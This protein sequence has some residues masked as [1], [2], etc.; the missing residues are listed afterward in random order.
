FPGGLVRVERCAALVHVGD[1][2]RFTEH[3]L[4]G[5]RLLLAEDHPEKRRFAGAVGTDHADDAGAWEPEVEP[6][7]EQLVA[8]GLP[9]T[10]GLE[11]VVAEP[12]SRWDADL[13]GV[14]RSLRGLRGELLVSSEPR[15]A[16]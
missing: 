9:Q 14:R 16:L 1:L 4:A 5:V 13:P 15:L 7:E 10:L 12:R 8:E 3:E 2:D 11:H 6:V